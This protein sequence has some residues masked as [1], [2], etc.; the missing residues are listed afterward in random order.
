M[1]ISVFPKAYIQPIAVDR[2]MTVFEWIEAAR[3]LP[4]DGLEMHSVFFGDPSRDGISRVGDA[5][6]A[7][8]FEMPMLCASPDFTNPDADK[9]ARE[10]D[11]EVQMIAIT[12][13]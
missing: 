10:F 6:A 4:A 1:R 11:L 9:R 3:S 2:T 13:Q 7:A 8:D 5:L 12:D